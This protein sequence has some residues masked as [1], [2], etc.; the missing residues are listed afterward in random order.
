MNRHLVKAAAIS[1]SAVMAAGALPITSLAAV[2][3][4]WEEVDGKWYWYENGVKQGTEGRGKEIY[5]SGTDAWYWL[6][7]PD[8]VKAVSKDVYQESDAGQWAENEDGTGKWVRY[9]SDGHMIKGWSTTDAGTYYFDVV[10][11]TMAKGWVNIDGEEHHFN[12]VSGVLDGSFGKVPDGN[13]WKE[14]DGKWY[15]YENGLRQGVSD[16]ASY[17]GKEIYDPASDAW[18]W[19]DNIQKGAKAAGKDVYQESSGG[20]WVRYNNEGKMVKGWD[21]KDGKKYYFDLTTGAM[22]KGIVRINGLDY[23]FDE[24]TGVLQGDYTGGDLSYVWVKTRATDYNTNGSL[25]GYTKYDYDDIGNLISETKYN[26]SKRLIIEIKYT[27][28]DEGRIETYSYRNH[29][30]NSTNYTIEN[31]YDDTSGFLTKKV[32]KDYEDDVVEVHTYSYKNGKLDKETVSYD[33]A[34]KRI[35][36][37]VDY[38]YDSKGNATKVTYLDPSD[39]RIQYAQ[40]TYYE[41]NGQTYV[42]T[43]LIC[44]DDNKVLSGSEYEYKGAEVTKE[45]IYTKDREISSYTVYDYVTIPDVEEGETYYTT[46][47][48]YNK[49]GTKIKTTKYE[50]TGIEI[51]S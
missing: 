19:L 3:F 32:K 45:T 49:N 8:G 11:G 38:S 24:A 50:Y 42:K 43:S 16:D 5:D 28:D 37:Y 2:D 20:K 36:G 51:R 46:S 15:W 29:T 31:T 26:N 18:Y 23:Y 41:Y 35:I 17:R 12:P 1:I 27:Y 7:A 34:G 39:N 33:E 4:G 40:N 44:D 22:A 30:N 9:D 47:T 21:T 48:T 13:G 14:I 6:D 10:Y 25:S